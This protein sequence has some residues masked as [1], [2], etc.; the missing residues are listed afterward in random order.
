LSS[1]S[2]GRNLTRTGMTLDEAIDKAAR[3]IDALLEQRYHNLALSMI[4][5]GCMDGDGIEE[6]VRPPSMTPG[7]R[8]LH[9]M[10]C[11]PASA[12]TRQS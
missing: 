5:Q 4:A 11:R 3:Q 7:G 8:S 1:L 10:F 2:R 9:P 12:S 6:V